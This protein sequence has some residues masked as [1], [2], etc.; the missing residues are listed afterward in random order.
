M[1]TNTN[2]SI[3]TTENVNGSDL[4]IRTETS[5]AWYDTASVQRETEQIQKHP[6]FSGSAPSDLLI[7]HIYSYH[8]RNVIL[9]IDSH[10]YT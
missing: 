2:L 5:T 6:P 9:F 1:N 4:K 8:W 3:T 7:S 10:I